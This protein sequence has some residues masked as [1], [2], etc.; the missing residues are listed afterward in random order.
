MR[1]C[2][3]GHETMQTA[4]NTDIQVWNFITLACRELTVAL[5][6]MHKAGIPITAMGTAH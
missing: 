2:G 4:V 1:G 5:V 6:M 3:L